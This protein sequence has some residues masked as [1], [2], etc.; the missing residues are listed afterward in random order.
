MLGIGA[1]LWLATVILLARRR[2]EVIPTGWAPECAGCGYSMKGLDRE[3]VCPECGQLPGDSERVIDEPRGWWIF[4]LVLHSCIALAAVT[5]MLRLWPGRDAVHT[6]RCVLALCV[7]SFL[8]SL[9]VRRGCGLRDWMLVRALPVVVH[10]IIVCQTWWI[11]DPW[12]AWDRLF[13]ASMTAG[14]AS[15][16]FMA[17]MA[18]AAVTHDYDRRRPA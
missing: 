12:W 6:T 16:F 11:V 1:L 8:A 7:A 5:P 15:G 18:V 9:L 2:R 3:L 4:P 13:E 17:V 10:A 14:G